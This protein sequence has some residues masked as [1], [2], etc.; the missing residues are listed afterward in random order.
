MPR[1]TAGFGSVG[2]RPA[3]GKETHAAEPHATGNSRVEVAWGSAP[4]RGKNRTRQSR[5]PRGTAGFGSVGL[6]PAHLVKTCPCL[7]TS[8]HPTL[9]SVD[10]IPFRPFNPRAPVVCYRRNLPHWRQEGCTYFVTFRLI[11]SIP[12]PLLLAWEQERKSWLAAHGIG[13]G[14][15]AAEFHESYSAIDVRVRRAFERR[16][17]HRLHL[18][19]DRNHGRCLLERPVVREGL[20]SALHHFHGTRCWCG[21]WVI[22]PN[23]VH[24]LLVPMPGWRLE[25]VL[26]SIKGFV[27]VQAARQ[28]DKMGR[29]WQSES[30][31]RLVRDR[32]ELEA[33]RRYI[34]NN[35]AKAGLASGRVAVFQADWI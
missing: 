7:G 23:H 26:R 21:D 8:L 22:M 33:F 29:L 2:L 24:W 19:L 27:S 30:Y 4:R 1:G 34:A 14:L 6:R 18:E 9:H 15:P 32:T 31:D 25:D 3:Q 17:A 16:Q 10:R 5:M 13:P 28:E 12:R 35:P 20:R 11:D